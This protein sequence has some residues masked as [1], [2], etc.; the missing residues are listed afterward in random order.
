M[1]VCLLKQEVLDTLGNT[2]ASLATDR[3]LSLKI[4]QEECLDQP[5]VAGC[6]QHF[7]LLTKNYHKREAMFC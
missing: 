5:G 2:V 3:V 1:L 7:A 4:S 6:S